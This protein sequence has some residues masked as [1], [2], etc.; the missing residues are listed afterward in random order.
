MDNIDKLRELRDATAAYVA[1][2]ERIDALH[3]E[4]RSGR[5]DKAML[6]ARDAAQKRFVAAFRAVDDVHD[7]AGLG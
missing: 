1:A 6:D 2:N 3:D 7:G 5:I 4:G